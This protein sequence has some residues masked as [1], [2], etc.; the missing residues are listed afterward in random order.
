MAKKKAR[1]AKKK[2]AGRRPVPW[3]HTSPAEI[4]AFQK[5]HGLTAVATARALGISVGT[6]QNWAAG[7][8]ATEKK[9]RAVKKKM[10][11]FEDG[12]KKTTKKRKTKK[13]SAR[14]K[15][16]TR[17]TKPKATKTSDLASEVAL[18]AVVAYMKR[19]GDVDA[20][21]LLEKTRK[22]KRALEG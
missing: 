7:K 20:K 5:K 10:A 3:K 14:E 6:L 9:Q 12:G 22:I 18:E 19:G 1:K 21:N 13:K 16:R 8:S 11:A 17:K 4:K 15:K 2:K